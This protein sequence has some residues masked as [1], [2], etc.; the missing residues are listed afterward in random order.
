MPSKE[1]RF[2]MV[3]NGHGTAVQVNGMKSCAEC[4]H[5]YRI[6]D[7][8]THNGFM[9]KRNTDQ[10]NDI[11]DLVTGQPLNPVSDQYLWLSCHDE[12]YGTEEKHCGTEGKFWKWC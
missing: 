11:H 2:Y 6:T 12:R 7:P 8:D 9:C 5:S 3:R 4:R 1:K 10:T